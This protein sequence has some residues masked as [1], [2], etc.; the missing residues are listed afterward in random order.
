VLIAVVGWGWLLGG[1][2]EAGARRCRDEAAC[3]DCY[4]RTLTE[5]EDCAEADDLITNREDRTQLF[6][7]QY[8]VCAAQAPGRPG[9]CT[10]TIR[11]L[12]KCRRTRVLSINRSWTTFKTNARRRCG[13]RAVAAAS[14]A[15]RQC[16]RSRECFCAAPTTTST[17]TTSTSTTTTTTTTTTTSTT[18]TSTTSTSTTTGT[19]TTATTTTATTTTTTTSTTTGGTV[20][21]SPDGSDCQRACIARITA[22]CQ[23]DC[24]DSCKGDT[25]ALP[26]CR[27]A[28][29]NGQCFDLRRFCAP[30]EDTDF[31]ISNPQGLNPDYFACCKVSGECEGVDDEETLSCETT[32][33]TT[34]TSTTSSIATTTTIPGA[35]T[36]TTF[37]TTTTTLNIVG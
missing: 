32:T 22:S 35:T 26:K 1:P 23:S 5:V 8:G 20:P 13:R 36:T 25:E 6:N 29:R 34:T 3:R 4:D 31:E 24:V 37:T 7:V 17:T 28:C 12:N 18:V 30:S 9:S 33:T 27:R 15:R 16:L 11:A 14:K 10:L 21:P 19:G 2:P